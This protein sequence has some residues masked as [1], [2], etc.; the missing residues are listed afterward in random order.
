MGVL[1]CNC[2]EFFL[3]ISLRLSI[4]TLEIGSKAAMLPI[5]LILYSISDEA[6]AAYENSKTSASNA[7]LNSSANENS[8]NERLTAFFNRYHSGTTLSNAQSAID[9]SGELLPE[10]KALKE[11]IEAQIDKLVEEENCI[12]GEMP[13]PEFL[14]KFNALYQQLNTVSA[15]GAVMPITEDVLQQSAS[16]LQNLENKWSAEKGGA[17]S[18]NILQSITSIEYNRFDFLK[19]ILGEKEI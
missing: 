2:P 8:V 3:R 7:I 4:P 9:F 16:Y 14:E 1:P 13:S 6:R 18:N 5:P 17:Y 15:L 19:E 11:N 10:N 12:P